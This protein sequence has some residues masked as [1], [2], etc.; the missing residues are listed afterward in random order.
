V[1]ALGY[2]PF[3][4]SIPLK[5]HAATFSLDRG[6]NWVRIKRLGQ[7]RVLGRFGAPTPNERLPD[8]TRGRDRQRRPGAEAQ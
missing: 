7:F 2:K 1:G 6:K 5:Q 8:P 3:V 4:N